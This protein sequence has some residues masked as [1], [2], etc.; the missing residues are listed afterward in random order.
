MSEPLTWGWGAVIYE[1]I[2]KW[3][4]SGSLGVCLNIE[5]PDG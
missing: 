3:S 1:Y 5:L 2:V 4:S